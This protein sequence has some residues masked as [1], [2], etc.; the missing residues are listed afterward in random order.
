MTRTAWTIVLAAITLSGLEGV[1]VEARAPKFGVG[2]LR[3]DGVII[4]FATYDGRWDSFWPLPE[5]NLT[6]PISVSGIP[7][8]WWGP[9]PPLEDWQ[10][11]TAAGMGSAHVL[12]PDWVQIHCVRQIALKTDYR[13]DEL[14]PPRTA[15]PYPKDGLAVSPPQTVEK[16]EIVPAAARELRELIPVLLTSFNQAERLVE[17]RFGHPVTRRARE[18]VEPTIEAVY[19]FGTN[20][21]TYYVEAAR[22]YRQ[23]GSNAGECAAIGFGTGWFVRE[24]AEILALSMATDLLDCRRST[25]T[26]MLPLGVMRPDTDHLFWIAQFSGWN[27][28]RYVVLEIKKKKVDVKVN[29]WGGSC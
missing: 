1:R 20:P 23:I 15:Q 10:L 29:V 16:I 6:I 25:A 12:Q 24:G 18:G 9:T 2:I 21:R 19:A 13:K 11:W 22:P 28:E 3:R 8:R 14:S 4:P 27:H 26:Y 7:K 5:F 17:S